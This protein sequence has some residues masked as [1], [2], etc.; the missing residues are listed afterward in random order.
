MRPD[1][2]PRRNALMRK[3]HYL[4]FRKMCGVTPVLLDLV[5]VREERAPEAAEPL[6]WFL[7]T[8][9]KVRSR[10]DA[11]RVLAPYQ[12]GWRIEDWHRVLKSGCKVEY[13]GH[14]RGE[15]IKRA[16]TIN[17]SIA[18]R[19]TAMTLLGLRRRNCRPRCCT[20]KSRSWRS[21]ISRK[22]GAWRNRAICDGRC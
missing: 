16:V 22:T 8:S 15:K 3:H 5:H 12:L 2:V 21:G 4:R 13:L 7:L 11:E 9:V 20:R 19:L 6:E 18:P 10:A 14:R 1:E 17:A